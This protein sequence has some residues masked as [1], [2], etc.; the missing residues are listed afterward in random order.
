MR[1][2]IACALALIGSRA[3]AYTISPNITTKASLVS[4]AWFSTDWTGNVA[5]TVTLWASKKI[6]T[7]CPLRPVWRSCKKLSTWIWLVVAVR[8]RDKGVYS[9][10]SW[11]LTL[12]PSVPWQR[13]QSPC[14]SKGLHLGNFA[15]KRWDQFFIVIVSAGATSILIM[16]Y[17]ANLIRKNCI[18]W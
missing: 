15:V 11:R 10:Y 14:C 18:P 4:A 17:R 1:H 8:P 2:R 5:K 12:P 6:Y 9:Q 3:H 16:K 13:Q 7:K